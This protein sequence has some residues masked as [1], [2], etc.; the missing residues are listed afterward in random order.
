[1]KIRPAKMT[2]SEKKL[3]RENTFAQSRKPNCD[4]LFVGQSDKSDTHTR[5]ATLRLY[6]I[7]CR[8]K[9]KTYFSA[10]LS[11]KTFFSIC[12][13]SERKKSCDSLSDLS[14]LHWWHLRKKSDAVIL[15]R[16]TLLPFLLGAATNEIWHESVGVRAIVSDFLSKK[17]KNRIPRR[18]RSPLAA[19]SLASCA[20][21]IQIQL[22]ICYASNR[23]RHAH[24]PFYFLS[25]RFASC[26]ASVQFRIDMRR[27]QSASEVEL[28]K[29]LDFY[30]A[31]FFASDVVVVVCVIKDDF[32]FDDSPQFFFFSCLMRHE[33]HE[34]RMEKKTRKISVSN[35]VRMM[36][37]KK[38]REW[39][40]KRHGRWV[41]H[42]YWMD[43]LN[44]AR[45]GN[46]TR[47]V[48]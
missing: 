26:F 29:M 2:K 6:L 38:Q 40:R 4:C 36:L 39:E 43:F 21:S 42:A 46:W 18:H 13:R 44:A 20:Q 17:K 16:F 22:H 5:R 34:T 1:M 41:I 48:R 14:R 10:K 7:K 15:R 35:D 27:F 19:F 23:Y 25:R 11:T 33:P 3:K 8:R 24:F 37:Q 9:G 30:E 32:T 45:T 28:L 31:P 47:T 12:F